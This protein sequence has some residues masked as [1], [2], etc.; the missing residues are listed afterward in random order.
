M[1]DSCS[2]LTDESIQRPSTKKASIRSIHRLT[3]PHKHRQYSKN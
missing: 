1:L 3:S 2:S